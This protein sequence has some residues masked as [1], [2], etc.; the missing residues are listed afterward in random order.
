MI[1][2]LYDTIDHLN[3]TEVG[4]FEP[5]FFAFCKCIKDFL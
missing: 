4:N 3:N 2:K 1:F 5:N